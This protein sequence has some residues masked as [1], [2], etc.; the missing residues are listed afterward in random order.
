MKV[1]GVRSQLAKQV[2]EVFQVADDEVNA[3]WYV[4]LL[5]RIQEDHSNGSFVGRIFTFFPSNRSQLEWLRNV[6]LAGRAAVASR[7]WASRTESLQPRVQAARPERFG[8]VAVDCAKARSKWMLCDFYG[9]VLIPPTT[10]EHGRAKLQLATVKLREACEQYGLMDH[11]VAVE[12]TGTYHRPIQRAFRQSGSE[13]RL[14]H[15]FASQHYRLPASADTKTDDKDLE[16]IFRTAVNGFGLLAAGSTAAGH[17]PA[18]GAGS[19][20]NPRT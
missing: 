1:S 16:A 20:R 19:V 5:S 10:V 9:R 17:D 12:M 6:I 4:V 11:L 8:I 14:V 13:T 18:G 3:P 2:R 15:P 7:C